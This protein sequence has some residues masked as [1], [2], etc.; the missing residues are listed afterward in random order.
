MIHFRYYFAALGAAPF[1]A[2]ALARVTTIPPDIKPTPVRT[3]VIRVIPLEVRTFA[4]RWHPFQSHVP[5]PYSRATPVPEVPVQTI[6]VKVAR[7]EPV[8]QP[9]PKSDVCSRHG[10]RKVHYGRRWRCRK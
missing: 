8:S 7:A 1:A 6:P 3:E 4:E 10:M 2:A 9:K 5:T